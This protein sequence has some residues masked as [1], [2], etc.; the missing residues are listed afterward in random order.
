MSILTE[1]KQT[2]FSYVGV[3][4]IKTSESVVTKDKREKPWV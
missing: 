1:E 3:P 2:Q 4:Q